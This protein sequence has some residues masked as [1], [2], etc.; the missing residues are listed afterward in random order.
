MKGNVTIYN[1]V[2]LNLKRPCISGMQAVNR[3]EGK[4]KGLSHY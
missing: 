4:F 1:Y 3:A 2:S